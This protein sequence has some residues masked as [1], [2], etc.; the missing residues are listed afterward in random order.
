MSKNYLA[1]YAQK[2]TKHQEGG[3]VGGAPAE[4]GQGGGGIQEMLMQVLQ[5]QD[6]NMALEFCNML[7]E[8]MG[9]GGGQAAAPGQAPAQAPMGRKGM[10]LSA[11]AFKFGG[12]L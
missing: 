1:T 9:I 2:V 4:G 12:K 10:T 8:Q 3:P 5:S 11:P 7:G 6:P